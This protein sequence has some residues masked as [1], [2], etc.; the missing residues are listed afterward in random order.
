MANKQEMLNVL[1]GTAKLFGDLGTCSRL[2][3]G[4]VAASS[5]G[6]ILSSG[7]NGAASGLPHCNH[8]CDCGFGDYTFHV[9]ACFSRRPCTR[10]VHAEANVIARAAREQ[11][12]LRGATLVTTHA[13]CGGCAGLI[14]QA[15][16]TRVVYEAEYRDPK[17]LDLLRQVGIRVDKFEAQ[18]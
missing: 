17:A 2:Q 11:V 18:E 7:Y 10:A 3:V 4:A 12:S 9:D 6:V 1:M 15:G 16:I 5:D 14:I 8:D 13:T